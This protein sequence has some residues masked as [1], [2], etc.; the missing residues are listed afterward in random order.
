MKTLL[1]AVGAA[2]IIG[3]ATP[4]LAQTTIPVRFKHGSDH[5]TL[6]GT[7]IGQE[8][9]DY[10][11][12]ASAGQTMN[13]SLAVDG[14]NGDGTA[15]FNILPPGSTGE[16]I[17]IGSRDGLSGSVRLPSSGDYTIRVYLMGNDADTDKTV[18]FSVTA[19]IR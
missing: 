1:R 9:V 8:Y 3:G 15:Y 12:G 17:F 4:S 13:V 11:L 19:G 10:V 18:G 7:I 16:A 2:M 14:T 5:A 6:N